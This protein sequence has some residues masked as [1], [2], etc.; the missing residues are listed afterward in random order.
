[1]QLNSHGSFIHGKWDCRWS[2]IAGRLPGRTDNEIKNYWNTNI[3]KKIQA[4]GASTSG[5]NR[6]SVTPQPLNQPNPIVKPSSSKN[7]AVIRTKA[8]RCTKVVITNPAE[9]PEP[10]ISDHH[11]PD[12]P[13]NSSE[14]VSKEKEPLCS[15]MDD[16]EVDESFLSDFLDI[17]FGMFSSSDL[18]NGITGS[19]GS[20]NHSVLYSDHML[21][22]LSNFSPMTCLID[23]ESDWLQN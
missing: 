12:D 11:Q 18:K 2:L 9:Q 8:R 14:F 20:D 17:E 3:G 4:A 22:E 7:S 19:P 1:M 16:L 5:Q 6:R 21:H 15:I 10:Q 23:T 13:I